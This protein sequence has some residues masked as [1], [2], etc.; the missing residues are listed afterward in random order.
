MRAPAFALLLQAV[1]PQPNVEDICRLAAEVTDWDA[2]AIQSRKHAVAPLL[3]RGLNMAGLSIP[4][5][6]KTYS[7]AAVRQSLA[8]TRD[9]LKAVAALNGAGIPYLTF[10]GPTESILAYGNPALRSYDDVDLIVDATD[11]DAARIALQALGY[12]IPN[13]VDPRPGALPVQILLHRQGTRSMIDLHSRWTQFPRLYDL[14]FAQAYQRRRAIDIA[15]SAVQTLADEERF[16]FLCLHGGLHFWGKL[17]WICDLAWECAAADLDMAAL[18]QR[19]AELGLSRSLK[20]GLALAHDLFATPMPPDIDVARLP[21]GLAYLK[22]EITRLLEAH[23]GQ[24]R[25]GR[26]HALFCHLLLRDDN[27]RRLAELQYR[28]RMNFGRHQGNR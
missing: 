10:K 16:L 2:L 5:A 24:P 26:A 7:E 3:V 15:G 25:R 4:Q 17:N 18:S 21:P 9:L 1:R 22:S 13:V 20:L 28:W 14:P 8:L 19:A 12:T 27:D 11:L 6:L 23:P